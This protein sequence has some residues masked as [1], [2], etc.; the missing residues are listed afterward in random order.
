MP[1]DAGGHWYVLHVVSSRAEES[2]PW[3]KIRDMA[4]LRSEILLQGILFQ[5]GSV[6]RIGRMQDY[7]HCPM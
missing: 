4:T 7:A 3:R 1:S 2:T 6:R 5:A